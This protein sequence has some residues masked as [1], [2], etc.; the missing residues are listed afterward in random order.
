VDLQKDRSR[1]F[2]AEVDTDGRSEDI[3]CVAT[4]SISDGGQALT[5]SL[6]CESDAY[7]IDINGYLVAGE[8]GV[9]GHWEESTRNVS[10]HLTGQIADGQFEGVV[11]GSGFTAEVALRSTHR[12]QAVNI[13][14]YGGSIA[15]VR[16]ILR[17][18][19]SGALYGK[20]L[21]WWPS[22]SPPWLVGYFKVGAAVMLN[23]WWLT[24]T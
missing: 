16:V 12:M 6:V 13:R 17:S 15:N 8:D 20:T 23:D 14:V 2:R 21:T 24:S 19:S 5:Q 22:V 18:E 10:G 7:R 4:Y 9:Q 1:G 11:V 3:R